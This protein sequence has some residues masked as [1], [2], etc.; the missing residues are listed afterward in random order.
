MTDPDGEFDSYLRV[1]DAD[2]NLLAENDDIE[3]GVTINSVI[4]G[5]ELTAGQTIIIEVGTYD[6]SS[7]GA[8]TLSVEA[9]E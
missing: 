8:F 9:A 2:G 5:L 6:N 3:L 4:E 7:A 1:Y